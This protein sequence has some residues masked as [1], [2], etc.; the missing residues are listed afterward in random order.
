M[1]GHIKIIVRQI[2]KLYIRNH[3]NV[4]MYMDGGKKKNNL[5][6]LSS[7]K[8]WDWHLKPSILVTVKNKI[9]NVWNTWYV[10]WMYNNPFRYIFFTLRNHGR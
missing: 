7:H 3:D 2:F 5:V 6:I 10:F 1:W 9:K 8:L 4:R